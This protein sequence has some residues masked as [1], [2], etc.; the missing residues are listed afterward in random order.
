MMTDPYENDIEMQIA[1]ANSDGDIAFLKEMSDTGKFDPCCTTD[2]AKWNYLHMANMNSYSPAPLSTMH[3]YLDKGVEVNAQ[4]CYGMTPL[5]YAMRA[6][7]GDA[8]LA[9]LEAGANPTI[10]NQ[11]N[12]IPLGMMGAMPHRLDVLKKMLENG[13]NVHYKNGNSGMELLEFAKHYLSD[14]DGFKEVIELMEQYA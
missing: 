14:I 4:D 9:L 8:A 2:S 12:V 10:P 7:N 6:E 5:H 13:G 3:F 1:R 11:D